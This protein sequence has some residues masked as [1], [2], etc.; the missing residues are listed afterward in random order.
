MAE[1]I[2]AYKPGE[3]V[4][5]CATAAVLEGRFVK[6]TAA[7]QTNGSYSAAHCGAGEAA[8]AVSQRDAIVEEPAGRINAGAAVPIH[9]QRRHFEGMTQGVPRVVA[10]AAVAAG[11]QVQSDAT[12]RAITLAG[13]VSLGVAA[14]VAA[15]A[16][17]VIEVIR[18]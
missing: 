4:P 9:D 1:L 7:Q 11:A 16:G 6:I 2:G 18:H 10:G 8:V 14:T 17:D 12:G 3:N 15:Q 13:G 5:F